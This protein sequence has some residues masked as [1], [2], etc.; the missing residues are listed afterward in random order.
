MGV[1]E[2]RQ[3]WLDLYP[4]LLNCC[5]IPLTKSLVDPIFSLTHHKP[6]TGPVGEN[7]R[8]FVCCSLASTLNH[9]QGIS[10]RLH[11]LH[12]H[13][14]LLPLFPLS[15]SHT[16]TWTYKKSQGTYSTYT[17]WNHLGTRWWI[18]HQCIQEMEQKESRSQKTKHGVIN[19]IW[20]A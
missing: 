17:H 16:S 2:Y 1:T 5:F 4:N 10:T 9:F 19:I 11:H 8:S 7:W 18:I 14:L 15:L 3:A 13:L 20:N 12:L 6:P